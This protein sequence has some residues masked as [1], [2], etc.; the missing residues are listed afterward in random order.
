MDIE[1]LIIEIK[2]QILTDAKQKFK[3]YLPE[4][5]KDLQKFL[6]N[7]EEKLKRW[8]ILLLEGSITKDEFEWLVKS[9]QNLIQLNTLQ[10]AGLSKIKLNN[11]KNNILKTIID[12][13]TKAIIIS[14]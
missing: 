12:T 7:S 6:K 14:L 1:K 2:Q 8:S 3:D 5:E 10:V 11:L 4:L 9:Q 13:T